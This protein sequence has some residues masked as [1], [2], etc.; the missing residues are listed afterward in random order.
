M[1][2]SK[3]TFSQIYTQEGLQ[4]V[5][6][7]SY[8]W[9]GKGHIIHLFRISASCFVWRLKAMSLKGLYTLDVLYLLK[10]FHTECQHHTATL[11]FLIITL[12]TLFLQSWYFNRTYPKAIPKYWTSVN[13]ILKITDRQSVI[14][15]EDNFWMLCTKSQLHKPFKCTFV[16]IYF[17]YM[18]IYFQSVK[19]KQSKP[20]VQNGLNIF[21]VQ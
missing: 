8:T 7:G 10:S 14:N 21:K 9:P 19:D 2:S 6:A 3:Q 5:S 17:L 4:T 1:N 13:E 15:V 16:L 20:T 18:L 12:I 11:L